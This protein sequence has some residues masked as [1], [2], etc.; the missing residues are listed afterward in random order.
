MWNWGEEII[1]NAPQTF[2]WTSGEMVVALM[3]IRNKVKGDTSLVEN[4]KLCFRYVKFEIL[5]GAE[6]SS[7]NGL[8]YASGIRW[9]V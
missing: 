8:K 5:T 4:N 7:K 9:A 2:T 1:K 3:E 6:L